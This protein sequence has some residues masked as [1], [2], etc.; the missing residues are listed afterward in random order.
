MK[1]LLYFYPVQVLNCFIFHTN[2]YFLC[3]LLQVGDK[4]LA[5]ENISRYKKQRKP[6]FPYMFETSNEEK[7]V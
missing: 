3:V 2:I 7:C 4:I 6:E 5:E 1:S